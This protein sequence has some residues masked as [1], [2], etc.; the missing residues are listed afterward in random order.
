MRKHWTLRL[1][2]VLFS[3][4]LLATACGDDD[5]GDASP[6]DTTAPDGTTAPDDSTPPSD[7]VD[8]VQDG[9][10]LAAVQDRGAVNCGVNDTL[11]GFG[12]TDA[13]GNFSGFDIDTCRAIAAAV[14]GDADAVN[15]TA[16]TAGER[17]TALQSGSID[18]LV[19]NTTWTA[20]RDGTEGATFL[21]TTFFDGQGIMVPA[22]S[23]AE[24]LEDLEGATI[25]VLSGTTTE[26]NL[27]SRFGAGGIGFTP[28]TFE[29]NDELNPAYQAGQCDAWTSDASQLAAFNA[30][31]TEE[32]LESK[33]LSEIFSKEP[34]GPV[35]ADGDSQWAQVVDWTVLAL[36]QAEEF[37][38]TQA[39]IGSYSGDDPNILRFVGA[40]D[41]DAGTVF[42]SGLGLPSTFAVDAVEAVGNY[43][44]LFETHLAPL[45]ISRGPNA[46]W[47]DG[48]LLY[49]PPFR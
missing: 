29:S 39:N 3:F 30:V 42:D 2:A 35:V 13:D 10:V 45:G 16:L 5:S 47:T 25:C 1:L 36:I 43:G 17:F 11:P 48:G 8:L 38:L 44:E 40:V 22:D 21:H 31:L 46:Q 26:L 20:S 7:T 6:D 49:A 27:A 19:R 28:L 18:V 12:I 37:G 4:T 23:P 9:S 14:L 34:L 15:F 41:A 32:G 33:I 24:T